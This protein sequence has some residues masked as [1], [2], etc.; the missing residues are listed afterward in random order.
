LQSCWYGVKKLPGEEKNSRIIYGSEG[1]PFISRDSLVKLCVKVGNR[2]SIEYYQVLG[3]FSKHHNKWFLHWDD[4]KIEF[5]SAS[6]KK[7]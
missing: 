7:L 1:N 3:L 2:V 5:K 4:D 6:K